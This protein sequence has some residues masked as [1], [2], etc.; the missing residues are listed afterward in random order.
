MQVRAFERY[1][2]LMAYG[3]LMQVESIAECS[4]FWHALS[5][6]WSWKPILCL[7]ES[8]RYTQVINH[9]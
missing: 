4:P 7:F 5:N 2:P 8:S 1:I 9:W 6:N 3:S